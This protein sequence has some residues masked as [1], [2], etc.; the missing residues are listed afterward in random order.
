M[1]VA[2]KK[3]L[4]EFAL[5][6]NVLRSANKARIT[7]RTVYL[8]LETD[9]EFK[10]LYELAREDAIDAL[11]EE[12][13]RR[14]HD[15]YLKPVYQ[16]GEMVG[17]IREFSDTLMVLLLKGHKPETYKDRVE[18]SGKVKVQPEPQLDTSVYTLE[19]LETLKALIEKQPAALLEAAKT[20]G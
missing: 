15:G 10:K 17:Q 2:Q 7:R 12:A 5:C 4:V 3:F 19:E 1:V 8:W 6:G 9:A 20:E 18:Q 14:A 13:R 11:E 16:Q